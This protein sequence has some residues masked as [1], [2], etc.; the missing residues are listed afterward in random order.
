MPTGQGACMGERSKV[1]RTDVVV[2]ELDFGQ[3]ER[4]VDAHEDGGL[5]HD[6]YEVHD[7]VAE[8][9]RRRPQPCTQSPNSTGNCW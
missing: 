2:D 1:E 3:R 8:E 9:E 6:V 5:H 4:V 7:L